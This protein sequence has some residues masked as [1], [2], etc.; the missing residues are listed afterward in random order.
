[1]QEPKDLFRRIEFRTVGG[2]R[3]RHQTIRPVDLPTTMT[4]SVVEHHPDALVR[5]RFSD[6]IEKDLQAVRLHGRQEPE[7]RSARLRFD[8]SIHPEPFVM[9]FDDPGRANA[10]EAKAPFIEGHR[11]LKR[12][13]LQ[14]GSEVFFPGPAVRDDSVD[15]AFVPF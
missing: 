13:R 12:L 10:F 14:Q 2:Q 3:K 15:G 9:I 6:L 11:R 4:G 7:E 5:P 8:R 1:M